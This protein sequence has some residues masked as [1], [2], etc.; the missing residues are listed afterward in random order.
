MN[1]FL[2]TKARNRKQELEQKIEPSEGEFRRQS[3]PEQ[4]CASL[5]IE[6]RGLSTGE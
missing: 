1:F 3:S 5:S 6:L 4:S 2:S